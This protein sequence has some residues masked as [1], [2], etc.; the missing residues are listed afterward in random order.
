MNAQETH[1][2]LVEEL[3]TFLHSGEVEKSDIPAGEYESRYKQLKAIRDF[4]GKSWN[5]I[6]VEIKSTDMPEGWIWESRKDSA[7]KKYYGLRLQIDK[8]EVLIK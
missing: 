6:E 4:F 2:K 1:L 8:M 5:Q 3:S 7:F